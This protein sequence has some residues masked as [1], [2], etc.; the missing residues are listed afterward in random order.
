MGEIWITVLLMIV[1]LIAEGFFSGSELGV[2]SADRMK[3]RHDAAKGSRGARLALEML[4]KA[5]GMV[6]VDD[7]GRHQYRGG[8]QL[9]DRNRADDRSVRGTW[10]LAGG[11]P[12][13]AAD[14]GVWRDRPE[15]R[16]PAARR[17]DHALRDLHPA[18][19]LDP[20]LANPHHL[21]HPVEVPFAPRGS[22]DEH[23]P[24]TLR[25]QIQSMVQMPPQEGGDIQAIEKTMIRR[26]FNFSETT[27]YKVMVPLIDVNAIEKRCTVG[28]AVRLAVQCSHVRLPVYDGRIDRVIGVLNSMDLLGVDESLRRSSPSSAQRATCRP[29]RAPSRCSS[30]CARMV[31]RWPW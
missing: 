19:L 21:R 2:V 3:L 1:C 26:M 16:L 12:G 31:M 5:A 9:D 13:C 29:A 4:E 17:Y 7:A 15:K 28:E 25:E 14:L 27:V 20:L 22:R 18:L 24:F 6:A 30:S 8:D 23:N 10:Q 11:G